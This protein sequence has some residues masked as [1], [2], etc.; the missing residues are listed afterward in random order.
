VPPF[1]INEVAEQ[2]ETLKR[3]RLGCVQLIDEYDLY[4]SSVALLERQRNYQVLLQYLSGWVEFYTLT[5]NKDMSKDTPNNAD[6][7]I[8]KIYNLPGN[9]E[10]FEY[11][12]NLLG[13]DVVGKQPLEKDT[14]IVESL[15]GARRCVA[16]MSVRISEAQ[17]QQANIDYARKISN[18]Q[19][20]IDTQA[21]QVARALL[22]LD[23]VEII[24]PP[25]NHVTEEEFPS[26]SW[27]QK[28]TIV[29]MTSP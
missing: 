21:R 28:G 6:P 7:A 20:A 26:G 5:Q 29:L 15:Q 25:K 16:L 18:A 14:P 24:V 19:L 1:L 9:L 10:T 4:H 2:F 22:A 13:I 27:V 3:V 11:C 23:N 17:Q 12:N 8:S